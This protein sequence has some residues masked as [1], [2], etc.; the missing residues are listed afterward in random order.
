MTPTRKKEKQTAFLK[1]GLDYVAVLIWGNR[2]Q[3]THFQTRKEAEDFNFEK[4][5][6][7]GEVMTTRDAIEKFDFL[8]L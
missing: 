2:Y 8:T 6:R 4:L 7:I 5:G 3:A 1:Q